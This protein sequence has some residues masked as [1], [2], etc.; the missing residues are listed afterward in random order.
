MRDKIPVATKPKKKPQPELI[1]EHGAGQQPNRKP[2]FKG[3]DEPP[4]PVLKHAG[5]LGSI[6]DFNDHV[7]AIADAHQRT[8]GYLPPPG[9]TLDIAKSSVGIHEYPKMFPAINKRVLQLGDVASSDAQEKQQFLSAYEQAKT[10]GITAKLKFLHEHEQQLH[11]YMEDP[12]F[13]KEFARAYLRGEKGYV[14]RQASLFNPTIFS[15]IADMAAKGVGQVAAG[16]TVGPALAA[17]EEGK[18]GYHDVGAVVHGNLPTSLVKTNV[19]LGKSAWNGV[20]YDVTH[21]GDAPGFLFLDAFG[22]V[23][24][25]AGVAT[26]IGSA[27]AAGTLRGAAGELVRRPRGGTVTLR[28]GGHAEEALLSENQLVAAVQKAVAGEKNKRM[29]KRFA[30]SDMPGGVG[31]IARMLRAND[32]LDKL[33]DPST[34]PL[35]GEASLRREMQA[36]KRTEQILL[37]EPKLELDRVAG[38]SVTAAPILGRV[39]ERLPETARRGLTLGEQK[40]LQVVTLDDPTPLATWRSFHEKMLDWEIGDPASHRAQLSALKLAEK[41]LK[42]PRKR[43]KEALA[44][45]YE[46]INRQE[47]IKVEELGLNPDT[48]NRRVIAYGEVVRSGEKVGESALPAERLSEHSAYVPSFAKGKGPRRVSDRGPFFEMR[49]AGYGYSPGRDLAELK[50]EFTGDSIRAGDFRVDT[51]NLV[52]EAYSRTVRLATI[53]NDHRR[54]WSAATETPRSLYDRPI[55]D[56]TSVPPR[57]KKV[58]DEIEQ[59]QVTGRELESLHPGQ[60]DELFKFLYPG[61]QLEN[62]RWVIN[63]PVDE[64]KWVSAQHLES[65]R[66]PLR[67]KAKLIGQVINEP[68]RDATLF[69]RLAYALNAVSNAGMLVLHQGHH[70]PPNLARA[71]FARKMYG[72]RVT[73]MLDALVGQSKSRSYAPDFDHVL[74]KAGRA[75]AAVWNKV[76]DQ[77]FRR[78]AIIYELQRKGFKTKEQLESALFDKK[79]LDAVSEA[80]R[81]ANKAMVEFDNLTWYEREVLRNYVFVY[82]WVSRSLVWSLRSI[83]E[84]PVKVDILAQIGAEDIREHPDVFDKVPDW[85]KKTGYVPVGY[86]S[87]GKPKIIN[88]TSINVFTTLQ[89]M[90]S[91]EEALMVEGGEKSSFNS[92]AGLGGPFA[93][94]ALHAITGRDDFGNPYPGGDVVGAAKEVLVGLPQVSARERANKKNPPEKGLDLTDRA[95]LVHRE[96]AALHRSVFSPGWLGGYGMLVSG[97]MTNRTIDPEAVAARYWAEQPAAARHKHEMGLVRKGLGLQADLLKEKLPADVTSAVNLAGKRTWAYQQLTKELGRT[98]TPKEQAEA[99]LRVFAQAGRI[100][101]AKATRL[102][103]QLA[104]L[105]DP[106]QI[107]RFKD[108]VVERFGHARALRDWDADVRLVASFKKDTLEAKLSILRSQGLTDMHTT[109]GTQ[110][111]LYQAGRQMLQYARQAR[112]KVQALD[113]NPNPAAEAE[114]RLWQDEQDHPLRVNG[115]RVAPSPVRLMWSTQTAKEK[116]THIASVLNRTWRGLSNFDKELLGQKRPLSVARGWARLAEIEAEYHKQNPGSN[117]AEDQRLSAVKQMERYDLYRGILKD[118]LF[119]REPKIRRLEMTKQYQQMG[120]KIRGQ[121]DR[122]IGGQAK[123]FATALKSGNYSNGELRDVWKNYVSTSLLPWLKQPEQRDL[124]GWVDAHGGLGFL[125]TLPG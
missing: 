36:R 57:L 60:V 72:D 21:P 116:Q 3:H 109:P 61:K 1:S 50:H 88:P 64:V 98:P 25:G 107:S 35:S 97:G 26:R 86:D 105:D 43:F 47:K 103:A 46:A 5:F 15:A 20:K 70:A 4:N 92:A 77:A 99:D 68:I 93:T 94:F 9:L 19:K 122:F 41:A 108:S 76:A 14:V 13:K 111:E 56:T 18:A 113:N 58:L 55:R 67:T 11:D 87:Q 91:L 74:L 16:L 125:N 124:W 106:T 53:R 29:Q 69:A 104:K 17:Y 96:K 8:F 30:G 80:K 44:L 34:S 123:V 51:T 121:F 79:H 39:F 115:K 28:K 110:E 73:N 23:S 62:G 90:V 32:M 118:Y 112:A 38:W 7:Q 54:L 119:S 31:P 114:L 117:I 63:E 6:L 71:L 42:N 95:T 12:E 101:T 84:H 75:A 83:V 24:A 89:E 52:G 66:P 65:F 33:L 120:P 100:S 37:M 49:E 45:T 81:R 22:L 10:I 78:A 27:T 102:R 59:G 85:F 82:P 48:A 40:A 2:A